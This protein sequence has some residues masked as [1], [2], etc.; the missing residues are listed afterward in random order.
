MKLLTTL[1]LAAA[2]PLAAQT[3]ADI[4]ARVTESSTR[5]AQSEGGQLILDSVD[6]HGGL[7]RWFSNGP[8]HFRWVYRLDDKGPD[9]VVDTEQTI[10]PWSSKAVHTVPSKPG[11]SFG[12]NDGKAWINPADAE[13]TPPPSFWALTPYY[14]VGLPFVLADPG[15]NFEL[16][17]DI[18]FAGESYRQVKVTYDSGT[19]DSPDDYYIALIDPET[20]LLRGVRYI[21]TSPVVA[22]DGPGPEKF[23]THEGLHE[24]DGILLPTSHLT[25]EVEGD[26]IGEVIR[27]AEVSNTKFLGPESVDFTIPDTAKIF[28]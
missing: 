10:D 23:L 21:V 8:L 25:Y 11:V 7:E 27:T 1:L 9:A 6:A 24:V 22:P 15:T 3:A 17:A 14:F 12:W 13:F 2:L 4:E 16:L 19:G 20:K 26:T 18:D 5:L 28:E